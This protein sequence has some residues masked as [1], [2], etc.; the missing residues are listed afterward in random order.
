MVLVVTRDLAKVQLRVRSSLPA[1]IFLQQHIFNKYRVTAYSTFFIISSINSRHSA[2]DPD[3]RFRQTLESIG[4]VRSMAPGCNIVF[5]DNSSQPLTGSS[6][7]VLAGMVDHYLDYTP[8]LFARWVNG[9][10]LNKGLNELIAYEAMLRWAMNS[11]VLGRRIFKLSGRYKLDNR[12]NIHEWSK[13]GYV[14]KYTFRITPWVFTTTAGT[15]VKDFYN[16]ALWSMCRTLTD[17]YLEL[18]DKIFDWMMDRGENIEMAHNYWI[19]KDKLVIV[20][21]LGGSGY[22]TNG[23]LTAF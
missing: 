9:N 17:E 19:P 23:E 15:Y 21:E 18:L 14:G 7:S 11:G 12:F 1:P 16:T 10:G 8:D 2:F 22:I 6:K 3:Q 4:S 5:L 13:P 20:P